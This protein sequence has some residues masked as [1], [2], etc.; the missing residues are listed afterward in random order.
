MLMNEI[1]ISVAMD[2]P[3]IVKI[4]EIFE[5]NQCVYIVTEYILLYAVSAREGSS[6]IGLTKLEVSVR[7]KLVLSLSK[8]LRPSTI[9]TRTK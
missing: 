7:M 2:N 1:E 4:Y 3:N 6:L 5:Y 8:W 9:Y